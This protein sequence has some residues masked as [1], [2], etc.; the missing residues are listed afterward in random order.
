[1]NNSNSNQKIELISSGGIAI[2]ELLIDHRQTQ[3]PSLIRKL[4]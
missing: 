4:F 1:M 2:E 3:I